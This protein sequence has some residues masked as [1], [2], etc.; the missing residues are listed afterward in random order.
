MESIIPPSLVSCSLSLCLS[1]VVHNDDD[2]V[3]PRADHKTHLNVPLPK[4]HLI[5]FQ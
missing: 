5:T 2:T 3:P 4:D 1:L